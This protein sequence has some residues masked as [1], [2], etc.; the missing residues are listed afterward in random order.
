MDKFMQRIRVRSDISNVYRLHIWY[1]NSAYTRQQQNKRVHFPIK[2]VRA[3]FSSGNPMDCDLSVAQSDNA[4]EKVGQGEEQEQEQKV[5]TVLSLKY[6]IEGAPAPL[7]WEW[8]L[9]I[10][11]SALVIANL[12][13]CLQVL[14]YICILLHILQF[15]RSLLKDSLYAASYLNEK[16]NALV[17]VVKKKMLNWISIAMKARSYAEVSIC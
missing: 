13:L 16:L 3:A 17:E 14:L 11:D 2:A 15:Y 8:H 1:P 7:K 10:I 6:R 4:T 12:N 9:T 5:C